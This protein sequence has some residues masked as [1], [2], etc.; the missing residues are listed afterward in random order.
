MS[1]KTKT[2]YISASI[3][4]KENDGIIDEKGNLTSGTN[5]KHAEI[6]VKENEKYTIYNY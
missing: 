3:D 6:E 1:N 4:I 5:F 2:S